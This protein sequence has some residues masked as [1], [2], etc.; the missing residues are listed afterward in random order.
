MFYPSHD[1]VSIVLEE[2]ALEGLDGITLQGLWMRISQRH[3]SCLN[4]DDCTKSYIWNL[5][6]KLNDVQMYE[7]PDPRKDLVP[8]NRFDHVD[9]EMGTV[10]E[11][12]EDPEDI[13][14]YSPVEDLVHGIK[15]S[16]STYHLQTNVTDTAR[17]LTIDEA[18]SRWGNKLVM[19]ASQSARNTVLLGDNV[20]PTSELTLAH[21]CLLERI[22]RSR[23][24]GEVTIG[25]TSL[26]QV[27]IDPKTLFYLR[28]FLLNHK[29]ITK[30]IFHLKN[31]G[32]NSSGSLLHLTKFYIL[33]RPKVL[34]L[35][36]KVVEILK[37]RPDHYA[38]YEEIRQILGIHYSLKKLTKSAEFQKFVKSDM[39]P[40]RT[41]YPEADHTEWKLKA[42]DKEKMI[43]VVQ[44]VK[45]DVDVEEVWSK[46]DGDEDDDSC[47][48]YLD[49][50]KI[51]FDRPLLCQAYDFFEKA[52]P[53]GLSKVELGSLMGLSKLEARTICRNLVKCGFV[54]LYMQDVGRQRVTR[55]VCRKYSKQ[56]D[57]IVQYEKEKQKMIELLSSKSDP[58]DLPTV[59]SIPNS[60]DQINNLNDSNVTDLNPN[61]QSK[62][63][64]SAS[65]MCSENI[66]TEVVEESVITPNVKRYK[67]YRDMICNQWNLKKENM[68]YR[69]LK[70]ANLIMECVKADKVIYDYTKLM[71]FISEEEDK[72]GYNVKIDKRSFL[73]LI[74]SLREDGIIK[75]INI[76]LRM[77]S[78][79]RNLNFICDPSIAKDDAVIHS[80]V[81]QAKVKF[82]VHQKATL[83]GSSGGKKSGSG[84]KNSKDK[85][86]ISSVPN[87]KDAANTDD[88]EKTTI[89]KGKIFGKKYGF[90][91]KFV[92][93]KLLHR[94]LFYLI[95]GYEGEKGLDQQTLVEKIILGGGD[96]DDELTQELPTIYYPNICWKTFIPP[97]P[98]HS[99]FPEG[100]TFMSDW[101]LRIP[102]SLF[103][104]IY[105]VTCEVP[106]I[107]DYLNHPI[108]QH[109]LVGSLPSKIK[110]YLMLGRRY[111]FSIH[112]VVCRLCF[113]GLVQF[114]PQRLKDK[115]QVFI[116]L[117]RKAILFDTTPSKA[118]YHQVSDGIDYEQRNYY[119]ET[120]CDLDRYWYDMWNICLKTH[121]GGR[122]CVT[123]ND[124]TLEILECK[125]SMIEATQPKNPDEAPM[126]DIGYIPG[127]HKGA[128]GLDS[129]IFSHLK[130]NWTKGNMNVNLKLIPLK[131]ESQPAQEVSIRSIKLKQGKEKFGGF[132]QGN[133]VK[134]TKV[135]KAFSQ[136]SGSLKKRAILATVQN[137]CKKKV[138]KAKHVVRKVLPR[139]LRR[140]RPYYDE[141]DRKALAK[142]SKLRVDWTEMEDS[143]LLTCKVAGLYFFPNPRYL[144]ISF[145]AIRDVLHSTIKDSINKTSRACQRRILYVMRNPATAH[146][147]SLSLLDLKHDQSISKKFEGV[148]E[149]AKAVAKNK[150]QLEKLV[151]PAFVELVQIL[152]KREESSTKPKS[153][154]GF[155][156]NDIAEFRS[157]YD[158][159][160]P[161]VLESKSRFTDVTSVDDIYKT[162]LHT[163]IHSSFCCSADK[164]SYAYQLFKVYQQYPD[165]FIKASMS[166]YRSDQMITLKK[167]YTS[168]KYKTGNFVPISSCPYQLSMNYAYLFQT[169]YQFEIFHQAFKIMRELEN[170]LPACTENEKVEILTND[171]GTAALLIEYFCRDMIILQAGIPDQIIIL[172]PVFASK[173]D[174]YDGILK[175]FRQHLEAA[176]KDKTGLDIPF[177]PLVGCSKKR[178]PSE[179]L[180]K[181]NPVKRIK[182]D[183]C[184]D[185][186][187][188]LNLLEVPQSV[189][190]DGARAEVSQP[191]INDDGIPVGASDCQDVSKDSGEAESS[192]VNDKS[193]KGSSAP[194]EENQVEHRL[195]T[196][197]AV[198]AA[199][200]IALFMMRKELTDSPMIDSHHAHDFFVVNACDIYCT[201]T[202]VDALLTP[203]KIQSELMENVLMQLKSSAILPDGYTPFLD[204]RK[205]YL[206]QG[207][208][209]LD[210][211]YAGEIINY[212]GHAK[213]VGVTVKELREKFGNNSGSVSLVQHLSIIANERVFIRAGVNCMRYVHYEYI[214]PWVVQSNKLLRLQ[215]ENIHPTE[216]KLMNLGR[217]AKSPKK[218]TLDT[219]GETTEKAQTAAVE[220]QPTNSSAKSAS[221]GDP[222]SPP[223]PKR[224]K[225]RMAKSTDHFAE[226]LPDVEDQD[227]NSSENRIKVLIKP[228]I[229]VD[230]SLN[231]RVLDRFLG[232]VLGHILLYPGITLEDIGE[233]FIPALQPCHT[234]E[235]VE[236]LSDLKCISLG[237]LKM[238]KP[239][240]FSKPSKVEFVIPDGTEDESTILATPMIDAVSKLGMFVGDK[241]YAVDFLGDI[242]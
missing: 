38:E 36:Q 137:I 130:R 124:I 33:R 118:G 84:N 29:L 208:S 66:E 192:E 1:Y 147:V 214:K 204:L 234:R 23:Y 240:L 68:T 42:F 157:K 177:N 155:Q 142:M 15:G 77:K 128:A 125:E 75:T 200:R 241:K 20:D 99:G 209:A 188:A 111:I 215:R 233:R 222:M 189:K 158:I 26:Q 149:R 63:P 47:S 129:A 45:P 184:L 123:G 56:G 90:C 50:S 46:E 7:L 171:G 190:Q 80:A 91:P 197:N 22:G 162:V 153:N 218:P 195:L 226:N 173:K 138:E 165:S 109:Y 163:I 141:E 67:R 104:K 224:S 185:S 133:L 210:W 55:F 207:A 131:S 144:S 174:T 161:H 116:Y 12:E 57:I 19:V 96:V 150:E 103:V 191:L 39:L 53:S 108:R 238:E 94:Y 64:I 59:K 71:Q 227:L 65:E 151:R 48:G 121:L 221:E 134:V 198:C 114:G 148:V 21:Y 223:T 220:E 54:S 199:S 172:D 135:N 105:N 235:L 86:K 113:I 143:L 232:A 11:P 79:T 156:Q 159:A 107:E 69:L 152:T 145:Q 120:I 169:E 25:R 202:D 186:T 154:Q 203:T 230:G 10:V 237:A 74:N 31:Y 117:N 139:K 110:K 127:D 40:Y 3:G 88:K 175:R 82:F 13:Y 28:K 16:S 8:F 18:N 166:K 181:D 239:T 93:M 44:L 180:D 6:I 52:G 95:Y 182:V 83:I 89:V 187:G 122:M 229:R 101:L 17:K 41:V 61:T 43:R 119:L 100:W 176:Y 201:V 160:F 60:G 97:L 24:H 225:G 179:V 70:R 217:G 2:I 76:T 231:R 9:A 242:L 219:D 228:W 102:L 206:E 35:T 211:K 73:R 5:I 126:L 212:V 85:K 34:V 58:E 136:V 37:S 81:E 62:P 112:E 196:N 164:T 32:Q 170:Q 168:K 193:T 27:G 4:N 132:N 140:P 106:S 98:L 51:M 49:Q 14:P 178:R 30:Q 205:K 236:I 216:V 146:S 115:D 92:R 78:K 167:H 183:E 72:E 87:Q 213:E 194:S